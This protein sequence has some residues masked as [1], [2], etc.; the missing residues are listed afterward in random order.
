[1]FKQINTYKMRDM[2]LYGL[3]CKAYLMLNNALDLMNQLNILC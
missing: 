3:Y 2:K 1:M